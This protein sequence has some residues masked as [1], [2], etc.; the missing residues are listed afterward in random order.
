MR[1]RRLD[2][3]RQLRRVTGGNLPAGIGVAILVAFALAMAAQPVLFPIHAASATALAAP[4]PGHPFGTD[5]EGRDMLAQVVRGVRYAFAVP[6]AAVLLAIVIG[7]PAGLA[8]ALAGGRFDR[9]MLRLYQA[10]A[11]VPALLLAPAL[12]AAMGGSAMHA[13]IAIGVLDVVVFARTMRGEVLALRRS[14]FI[15]GAVAMGNPLPRLLLVHL[16]PNVAPALAAQ[17]PRRMALALGTLALIGFL[18]LGSAPETNEWGAMIRQGWEP[19]LADQWWLGV[20]PSLAL[21]LF[22]FALNLLGE[23]IADRRAWRGSAAAG[24]LP[25]AAG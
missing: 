13:A 1:G 14:G 8:G 18:G 5:A 22:G 7:L 4:S 11:L 9:L 6:L 2:R 20:F 15:E 23:G 17:I 25:K 21:V 16:L 10:V 3:L 12:T 19:M 24:A